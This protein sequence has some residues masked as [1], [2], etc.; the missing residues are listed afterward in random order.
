MQ[1]ETL[2]AALKAARQRLA[3][4]SPSAALDAR[5][6]LQAAAHVGHAD[7]IAHPERLLTADQAARF[8]ALVRRRLAHEPVS[9]ILGE[10][11]FYGRSFTV[12]P[13][14]LDPRPDTE[15]LIDAARAVMPGQARILDLG[16]GSGIIAVTL[17]CERADAT[18]FAVDISGDALDVARH[19]AGRHDVAD[20][21]SL[22]QGSWFAPV[23]GTF[24]LILSNPPYIPDAEIATLAPDV[25]GF[26]PRES[27][28]GG[29]DGL[30]PYRF[31]AA[32]SGHHLKPGGHILVEIGTGQADAVVAIFKT[33]GFACTGRHLDLAG[34]VRCLLFSTGR[35]Q[36]R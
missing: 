6:L 18:G 2:G 23:T 26:D 32:G 17:L 28:A 13:A 30:E 5:L 7:I 33:A 15:T 12:T 27:L 22:A 31:I 14:V 9:R 8:E 34:H 10:R 1:P 19:N 25:R 3:A 16:T 35:K 20:R 21:I 36:A 11:E 4:T 24:D 29:E